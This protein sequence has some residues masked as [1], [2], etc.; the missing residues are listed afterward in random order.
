[1]ILRIQILLVAL[2]L[3]AA[4]R[5]AAEP[6]SLEEARETV[7]LALAE[8]FRN[9]TGTWEVEFIRLPEL[10]S[11]TELLEVT[12]FP[13]RPASSM[14]LRMRFSSASEVIFEGN[15]AIRARLLRDVLVAREPITRNQSVDPYQF[16]T[17]R[18]DVLR[19]NGAVGFDDLAEGD[20]LYYRSIPA[21]RILNWR[22]IVRRPVVQRGQ[23]IEVA[24]INGALSV[25]L[26]GMALEDGAVGELI[27]IRNPESRR[28][29]AALV[30]GEG[31]AEIRL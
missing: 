29:I 27:R 23:L 7:A 3:T 1:M 24:A 21:G 9:E 2:L 15:V 11:G 17:Q 16:D 14:L 5:I 31:R 13:S 22:D 20:F 18:V 30:V 6:L 8:Q 12:T 26:K 25:V 28:E 10:P 19:E 4:G